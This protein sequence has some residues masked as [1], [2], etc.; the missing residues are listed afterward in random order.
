MQ[1]VQT[2]LPRASCIRIFE[3]DACRR[4]AVVGA[5]PE[6]SQRPVTPSSKPS[7][8]GLQPWQIHEQLPVRQ[9]PVWLL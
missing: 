7:P 5:I 3:D 9:C 8:G 2:K 6:V 1:R 4:P